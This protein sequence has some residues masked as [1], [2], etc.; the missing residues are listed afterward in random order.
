MKFKQLKNAI[1]K[2]S[3]LSNNTHKDN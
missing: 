2:E 3:I 1:K